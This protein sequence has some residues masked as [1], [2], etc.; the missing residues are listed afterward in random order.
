MYPVY[1]PHLKDNYKL[2]PISE[3]I[4]SI[5]LEN[6]ILLTRVDLDKFKSERSIIILKQAEFDN[7]R[8]NHPNILPHN[9][10]IIIIDPRQLNSSQARGII[11]RRIIVSDGVANS[12]KIDEAIMDVHWALSEYF[13]QMGFPAFENNSKFDDIL[14]MYRDLTLD[15]TIVYQNELNKARLTIVKYESEDIKCLGMELCR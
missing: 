12:D 11:G 9:V 10:P 15:L 4:H 14:H 13:R 8:V 6:P 5:E 1:G 7:F 3:S 2:D